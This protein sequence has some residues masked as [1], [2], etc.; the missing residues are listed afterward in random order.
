MSENETGTA[1]I[2]LVVG[3][4]NPGSKYAGTRHNIGFDVVDQTVAELHGTWQ[5]K[6]TWNARYCF[7]NGIIFLKP[8][9]FMNLSGQAV[10]AVARFY[11]IAARQVLTVYDD[12][13]LPLGRLRIRRSGTSGGHNGMQSIINHLGTEQ[14]SRLRVGVGAANDRPLRQ[15][16]LSR[17]DTCEAD[18]LQATITRANEAILFLVKKGVDAAMNIYNKDQSK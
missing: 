11:R 18:E 8:Q 4:G 6:A 16:V 2:R 17:F 12:I 3:L 10:A 7:G 13:A 9:T 15:H 1:G 5:S 14:L